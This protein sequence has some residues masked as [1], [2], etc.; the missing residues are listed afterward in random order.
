M[1][2]D[3]TLSI[4]LFVVLDYFALVGAEQCAF[5]I[6]NSF[7]HSSYLHI[8]WLNF[9]IVFPS[10]YIFFLNMGQLYSRRRPFYKEVD[11]LFKAS[12]YGTLAVIFILYV[13]RIATHTS[14]FFVGAFGILAFLLLTL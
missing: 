10:L 2:Y 8:S 9:W 11:Q 14:R 5:W 7:F 3:K 13:S 1:R 6:R 12:C 4:L